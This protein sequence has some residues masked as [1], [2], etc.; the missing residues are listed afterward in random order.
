MIQLNE[1][2]MHEIKLHE[3]KICKPLYFQINTSPHLQIS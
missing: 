1:R 3:I 2:K